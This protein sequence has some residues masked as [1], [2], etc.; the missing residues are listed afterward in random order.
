MSSPGGPAGGPASAPRH[1]T[2]PGV[3]V[4]PAGVS[5][6][7]AWAFYL[8]VSS[9]P[10]ESTGIGVPVSATRF[11]GYLL[12]LVALL[13]SA[14]SF[15]RIPR[16]LCWFGL[17]ACAYATL[18][19]FQPPEFWEEIWERVF[20]LVQL[21]VL[22]WL[23]FNLLRHPRIARGA[24][25]SL[26][27]SCACCAALQLSGIAASSNPT[28]ERAALLGQN[29]NEV[30]GYFAVGLLALVGV[31]YGRDRGLSWF[32]PLAW[33][34]FAVLGGAIIQTG[35]RGG[36]LAL[37][38]GMV[39]F[40]LV[41]K[42][43]R[44]LLRNAAIVLLVGA[45]VVAI[46]YYSEESRRRWEEALATGNLAHREELFPIALEMFLEEPLV[47]WGPVAHLHE[48]GR[49]TRH[50]R[51]HNPDQPW[52]DTHNL[53]LYVLTGVGALGSLP[54]LIGLW[55]CLREAWRGRRG[56]AGLL[57]FALLATMLA[58][59]M[60]GTWMHLKVFWFVMACALAGGCPLPA[61]GALVRRVRPASRSGCAAAA[62]P[63]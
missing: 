53:F 50:L 13:N 8:F 1:D 28:Q 56:P 57:P 32:R 26:G 11:A 35:S 33:P 21:L 29:P 45:I 30:A 58:A 44:I 34:A 39:T 40:L 2:A 31:F 38:A 41:A 61:P 25:L 15:R 54:F 17:Y 3:S 37:G 5:R 9:L 18:G 23:T 63:S 62:T 60:S 6:P 19:L 59:N 7:L 36:L 12:V 10:V 22:L 46:S 49:R 55:L 16:A 43:P 52:R 4:A 20:T 14:V 24:F 47:G 48:L 42:T 51:W 27:V